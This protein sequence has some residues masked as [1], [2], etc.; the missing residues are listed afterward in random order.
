MEVT[1]H[2]PDIAKQ[3]SA[4]RADVPRRVLET[5][6]LEGYRA[7]QLSESGFHQMLG[8][9]TRMEVHAF[10]KGVITFTSTIDVDGFSR[11]K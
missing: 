11:W 4:T 9:E 7:E 3:L 6:A 2:I 5:I 1:L 10:L 8:F